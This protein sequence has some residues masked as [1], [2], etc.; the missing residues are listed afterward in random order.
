MPYVMLKKNWPGKFRRTI[1]T[2]K[3]GKEVRRQLKFTPGEPV[4]LTA[5]EVDALRSD[6]GPALQPVEFDEKARPRVITDDVIP[7]DAQPEEQ[8]KHEPE[9]VNS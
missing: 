1:T 2:R 8:R 6:I 7:D 9:P 5:A 4:E 3:K